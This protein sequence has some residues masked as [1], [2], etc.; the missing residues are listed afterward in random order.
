MHP[1][2]DIIDHGIFPGRETSIRKTERSVFETSV[3]PVDGLTARRVQNSLDI[4][5]PLE[6]QHGYGP[7]CSRRT[8]SILVRCVFGI[9]FALAAGFLMTE[10]V[11]D[12]TNDIE[13]IGER[14][15][16]DPRRIPT[17][18]SLQY[19]SR[20]EQIHGYTSTRKGTN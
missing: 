3:E 7:A 15:R 2:D 11:V 18:E 13:Q 10:G 1:K 4:E 9:G 20:A 12:D 17:H 19:L 16:H 8:E 6:I 14:V 5:E